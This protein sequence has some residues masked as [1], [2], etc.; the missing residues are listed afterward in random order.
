M[1]WI[2]TCPLIWI[3]TVCRRIYNCLQRWL[4]IFY[5]PLA[6]GFSVDDTLSSELVTSITS[7]LGGVHGGLTLVSSLFLSLTGVLKG[8]VGCLLGEGCRFTC[9]VYRYSSPSSSGKIS[10][11]RLFFKKN[12]TFWNIS[13]IYPSFWDILTPCHKCPKIGQVNFIRVVPVDMSNNCWVSSSQCRPWSGAST[14]VH[15]FRTDQNSL[16]FPWLP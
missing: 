2:V 6:Y 7:F 13:H 15:T 8:E 4:G 16:T 1:R 12:K 11:S 5:L 14:R 10:Q 9:T 3:C